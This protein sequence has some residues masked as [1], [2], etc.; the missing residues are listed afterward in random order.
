M[1]AVQPS[2][3][4]QHAPAPSPAQAALAD[5]AAATASAASFAGLLEK[6]DYLGPASIEMVRQA[7]HFADKAHLGQM[8]SSGDPYI[9]H[10]IAVAAQCATWKLDAPAL[11][12]A[13]QMGTPAQL[14]LKW[15][16]WHGVLQ[17]EVM[18]LTEES[19]KILEA[20]IPELAQG[21]FQRAYYE[22]L[23]TSGKVMRAVDGKLVAERCKAKG[24]DQV[25][26]D[27]GG[28]LYHGRVA[29]LAEGAREGGLE[30]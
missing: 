13:N 4:S 6:L 27:R 24:I 18:Q 25:V 28:Y 8:R 20:A 15:R 16:H 9:T 21:A 12:A 7:Y 2:P 3:S 5:A 1:T 30:F 17:G 26:F 23:T 22:A 29:E 11:M 19:M 14:G 10:P